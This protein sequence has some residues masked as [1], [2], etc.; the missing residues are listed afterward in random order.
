MLSM[1][2]LFGI[3]H[4]KNYLC[5]LENIIIAVEADSLRLAGNNKSSKLLQPA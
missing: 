1:M 4:L 5:V 3:K 2:S